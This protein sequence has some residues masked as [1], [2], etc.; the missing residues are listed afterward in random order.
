MTV[1]PVFDAA[2]GQGDV[3]NIHDLSAY[4]S[5]INC[6]D[7]PGVQ[8]PVG[9]AGLPPPLAGFQREV[10]RTCASGGPRGLL[11]ATLLVGAMALALRARQPGGRSIDRRYWRLQV[12]A[13]AGR[14][15]L[16]EAL[17]FQG[18]H[19][20]EHLVQVIQR[21]VLDIKNGGDLFGSVYDLEPVHSAYNLTFL[22]LLGLAV[23][24]LRQPGAVP[25]HRAL[26]LGLLTLT[27]VG[28]SYHSIEHVV[29]IAQFL[30]TGRDGTPGILERGSRSS[31][32]TS[33][34]IPY[35]SYRSWQCSSGAASARPCAAT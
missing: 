1:D 25:R 21:S 35:C 18:L 3:S 30:E 14:L 8:K 26:V 5:P 11:L 24:G 28:Q 6:D 31:D 16:L 29:K 27:L 15:L 19:E 9:G 32:S 4:P 13:Q 12:S 20:M 7:P 33:G 22:I 34:S 2:S 17:L 10:E 23:I